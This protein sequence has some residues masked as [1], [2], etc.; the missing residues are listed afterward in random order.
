MFEFVREINN[1][2]LSL[3]FKTVF[4]KPLWT[5]PNIVFIA[6]MIISTLSYYCGSVQK[7]N[8]N[9]KVSNSIHMEIRV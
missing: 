1:K 8:I 2:S 3:T 6:I 4:K 9:S 5:I 7:R